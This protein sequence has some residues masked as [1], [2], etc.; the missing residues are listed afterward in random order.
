MSRPV[1]CARAARPAFHALFLYPLEPPASQV[2]SSRVAPGQA[3][4]PT[5]SYQRRTDSTARAAVFP[6]VPTLTNPAL[7]F[8]S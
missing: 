5:A 1:S 2:T 3:S 8:W 4:F 7:A 6:S